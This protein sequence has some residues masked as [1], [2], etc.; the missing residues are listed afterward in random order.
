MRIATN[1]TR[2]APT[3]RHNKF[4]AK[5]F[6]RLRRETAQ[7]LVSLSN[8]SFTQRDKIPSIPPRR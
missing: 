6:E 7:P 3:Q 8:L 4:K 1:L 5:K 2:H